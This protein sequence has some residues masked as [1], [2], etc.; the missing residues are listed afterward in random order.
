MPPA[1]AVLFFVSWLHRTFPT[2][3]LV[4]VVLISQSEVGCLY[5]VQVLENVVQQILSSGRVL[6]LLD[7]LLLVQEQDL[8]VERLDAVEAGQTSHVGNDLKTKNGKKITVIWR[9][10]KNNQ[11]MT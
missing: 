10:L 7:E 9:I 8:H 1:Q 3:R 6:D 4:G 5:E 11:K 2:H